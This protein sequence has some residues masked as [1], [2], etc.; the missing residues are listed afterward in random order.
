[1]WI[2]MLFAQREGA[3]I[4]GMFELSAWKIERHIVRIE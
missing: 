1:M 2:D 3:V 4:R